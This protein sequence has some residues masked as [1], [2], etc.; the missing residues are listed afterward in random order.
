M[1]G[2]IYNG[3]IDID[4]IGV[5]SFLNLLNTY[6]ANIPTTYFCD[7]PKLMKDFFECMYTDRHIPE[8]LFDKK[9]PQRSKFKE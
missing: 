1:K 9:N 5:P 3:Q 4:T 8:T 6:C 2:F 7:R